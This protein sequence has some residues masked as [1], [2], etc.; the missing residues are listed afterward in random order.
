MKQTTIVISVLTFSILLMLGMIGPAQE[1]SGGQQEMLKAY[2]AELLQH[3]QISPDIPYWP[4]N[5]DNDLREKIIKLAQQM[6]PAPEIP[7]D[8]RKYMARGFAA[9][10]NARTSAD[11]F[12][13]GQEFK[14]AIQS[15]PWRGEAYWN[16]ALAFFRYNEEANK[17]SSMGI[18]SM[19]YAPASKCLKFYLLT[20]PPSVD[21]AKA[22][23][24]MYKIDFTVEQL[25]KG[26]EK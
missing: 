21:A 20:D 1:Q 12:A 4:N 23:E 24:L 17:E 11:L 16:F 25:N 7:E 18:H 10:K 2:V 15:A 5:E 22:R 26:R 19:F 3:E 9:F 13:A 8:Y 14:W 6:Q